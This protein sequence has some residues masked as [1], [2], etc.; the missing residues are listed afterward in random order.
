MNEDYW[1]CNRRLS[2]CQ[3]FWIMFSDNAS[4]V[5][6]LAFMSSI[7]ILYEVNLTTWIIR[8]NA[9]F[10]TQFKIRIDICRSDWKKMLAKLYHGSIL[11]HSKI[12]NLQ[13]NLYIFCL[14]FN[15]PF[16]CYLFCF[17]EHHA[18][19][20]ARSFMKFTYKN[21][22]SEMFNWFL[23]CIVS[24]MPRYRFIW[25]NGSENNS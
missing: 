11:Q 9:S 6:V 2:K 16:G 20:L 8:M 17:M 7:G 23:F 5:P 15:C 13:T 22:V 24:F 14:I 25:T 4:V 10:S 21:I 3:R 19:T 12:R 18:V 1:E